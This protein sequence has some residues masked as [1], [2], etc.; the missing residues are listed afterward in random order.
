[1]LELDRFDLISVGNWTECPP[2]PLFLLVLLAGLP[3]TVSPQLALL[4][5]FSLLGDSEKKG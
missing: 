1:M 2:T 5:L 3:H 4:K